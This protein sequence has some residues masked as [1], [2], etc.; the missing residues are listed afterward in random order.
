MI[1]AISVLF[2]LAIAFTQ[3]KQARRNGQWSWLGFFVV[4]GSM[5]GFGAAFLIPVIH[6]TSL[7]AHPAVMITVLLS[8]ILLF[9]VLLIYACRKYYAR[10]FP[11]TG[12]PAPPTKP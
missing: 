10:F 1:P 8:G 6:S 5:L 12:S 9:V 2:V 11:A 3:Y 7:Q 4:L